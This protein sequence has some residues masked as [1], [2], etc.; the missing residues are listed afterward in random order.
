MKMPL[1]VILKLLNPGDRLLVKFNCC[2]ETISSSKDYKMHA[3]IYV[4]QADQ[5]LKLQPA[6]LL[7]YSSD[8]L[9]RENNISHM[10]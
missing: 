7:G 8:S 1:D 3:R 10:L 9:G 4:V 6:I 2:L 5:K